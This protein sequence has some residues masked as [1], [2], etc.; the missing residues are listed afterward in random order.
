MDVVD[1]VLDLDV[2]REFLGDCAFEL[3]KLVMGFWNLGRKGVMP[4]M[5][6]E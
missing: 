2:E 6:Q 4:F 1:V 3:K 5:L